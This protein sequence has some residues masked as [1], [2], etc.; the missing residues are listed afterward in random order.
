MECEFSANSAKSLRNLC[1]ISASYANIL[2]LIYSVW[3]CKNRWLKG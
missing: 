3:L 1:E 2:L